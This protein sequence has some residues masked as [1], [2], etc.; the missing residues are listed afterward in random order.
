M[1][2]P[3]VGSR[4]QPWEVSQQALLTR[5]SQSGPDTGVGLAQALNYSEAK[6]SIAMQALRTA[7]LVV[8]QPAPP[9]PRQPRFFYE[10]TA[11]GRARVALEEKADE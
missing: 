11:T 1:P 7:G 5:L 6:V 4:R 3:K 8:R 9:Q 2:K 10:L